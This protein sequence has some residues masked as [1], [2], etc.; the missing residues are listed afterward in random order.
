M[1]C[2]LIWNI[3]SSFQAQKKL[4]IYIAGCDE[5]ISGYRKGISGYVTLYF[6][7]IP[8][9]RVEGYVSDENSWA[10]TSSRLTLQADRHT[11]E[12]MKPPR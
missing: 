11:I 8:E 4:R 5:G 3:L 2:P 1:S 6:G 10:D 7:R 12:I 9:D